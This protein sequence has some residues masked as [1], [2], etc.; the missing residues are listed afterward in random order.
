VVGAPL[1]AAEEDKIIGDLSSRDQL[2]RA[3][4]AALQVEQP[5][6]GGVPGELQPNAFMVEV[7]PKIQFEQAYPY[8]W[9]ASVQMS[10]ENEQEW[11]WTLDKIPK[12]PGLEHLLDPVELVENLLIENGIGAATVGMPLAPRRVLQVARCVRA[13]DFRSCC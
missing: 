10:R 2:F 12:E 13:C 11:Y 4:F 5:E 1:S 3:A 6:E 7:V 8:H 9:S